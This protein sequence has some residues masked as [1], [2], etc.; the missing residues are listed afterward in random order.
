MTAHRPPPPGKPA[1][2]PE[3]KKHDKKQDK[4]HEKKHDPKHDEG[5]HLL[6]AHEHLGRLEVLQGARGSAVPPSLAL[7]KA[8]AERDRRAHV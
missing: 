3:D 4:K 7:L 1:K 2:G 8:E 6:R 5:K